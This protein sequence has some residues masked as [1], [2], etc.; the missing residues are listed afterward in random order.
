MVT[1]LMSR[2]SLM[3]TYV[4]VVIM[5]LKLGEALQGA[6]MMSPKELEYWLRIVMVTKQAGELA[7][8]HSHGYVTLYV[9]SYLLMGPALDCH[10]WL[11]P[12]GVLAL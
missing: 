11:K 6:W 1:E 3:L 8:D 10:C 5:S 7:R 4:G 9:V 2:D 12:G